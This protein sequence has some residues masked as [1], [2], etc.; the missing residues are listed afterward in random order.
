MFLRQVCNY[1]PALI[2]FVSQT[3]ILSADMRNAIS[4]NV[5]FCQKSAQVQ[6]KKNA[7][8]MV[9]AIIACTAAKW[10]KA[11]LP[12]ITHAMQDAHTATDSSVKRAVWNMLKE[13]YELKFE[14]LFAA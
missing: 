6:I 1:A 9:T 2:T 4:R 7:L 5:A 8:V 10:W 3:V 14:K 11:V 13:T 12:L